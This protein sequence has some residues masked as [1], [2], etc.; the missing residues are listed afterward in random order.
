MWFSRVWLISLVLVTSALVSGALNRSVNQESLEHSAR[1]AELLIERH[2]LQL[3]V[4]SS[5]L[6]AQPEVILALSSQYA[7]ANGQKLRLDH[8]FENWLVDHPIASDAMLLNPGLSKDCPLGGGDCRYQPL[9]AWNQHVTVEDVVSTL[10]LR[11]LKTKETFVPRWG[12]VGEKAHLVV[13]LPVTKQSTLGVL[14]VVGESLEQIVQKVTKEAQRKNHDLKTGFTV[15]LG[16]QRLLGSSTK[17]PNKTVAK[18]EISLLVDHVSPSLADK[19]MNL[20]KEGLSSTTNLLGVIPLSLLFL[21]AFWINRP[22]ALPAQP[23]QFEPRKYEDDELPVE[24]TEELDADRPVTDHSSVNEEADQ[25]SSSIENITDE[26][27]L[28]GLLEPESDQSSSQTIHKVAI[29]EDEWNNPN[30]LLPEPM[31]AESLDHLVDVSENHTENIDEEFSLDEFLELSDQVADDLEQSEE[32]MESLSKDLLT[33]EEDLITPLP[34]QVI[35][36]ADIEDQF[37][38]QESPDSLEPQE[39]SEV[40]L[41]EKEPT[42]SEKE[43]RRPDEFEQFAAELLS[44]SDDSEEGDLVAELGQMF[45]EEL[46]ELFD[47]LESP[48]DAAA[49]EGWE[50]VPENLEPEIDILSEIEIREVEVEAPEEESAEFTESIDPSEPVSTEGFASDYVDFETDLADEL[51]VI[52]DIDL[53]SIVDQHA[54]PE[55]VLDTNMFFSH[56]GLETPTTHPK[57]EEVLHSIAPSPIE[58]QQEDLDLDASLDDLDSEQAEEFNFDALIVPEEFENVEKSSEFEEFTELNEPI[59]TEDINEPDELEQ[60]IF[61]DELVTD[62]QQSEE[63]VSDHHELVEDTTENREELSKVEI[64][65][66]VENSQEFNQDVIAETA[67]NLD[68]SKASESVAEDQIEEVSATPEAVE[69]SEPAVED[70]IE[71]LIEEVLATPEAVEVSEPAAELNNSILSQESDNFDEFIESADSLSSVE[72]LDDFDEDLFGLTDYLD[73]RGIPSLPP[74]SAKATTMVPAISA[75][76][77]EESLEPQ[78]QELDELAP[79]QEEFDALQSFFQAEYGDEWVDLPSTNPNQIEPVQNE[80]TQT[81]AESDSESMLPPVDDLMN[82]FGVD[83]PDDIFQERQATPVPA[84]DELPQDLAE[85]SLLKQQ[86]ELIASEKTELDFPNA[87][88]E[89]VLNTPSDSEDL[90]LTLPPEMEFLPEENQVAPSDS[91]K[92]EEMELDDQ[93]QSQASDVELESNFD[94][95]QEALPAEATELSSPPEP[96]ETFHSH[97]QDEPVQEEAQIQEEKDREL[98]EVIATHAPQPMAEVDWS[99]RAKVRRQARL[100]HYKDVYQEFCTLKKELEAQAKLPNF[101]DFVKQLNTARQQYIDKKNCP[102]VRFKIYRNKKGRAA[103]KAKAYVPEI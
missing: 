4:E 81:K 54:E 66:D 20:F 91:A 14:I 56:L 78:A 80:A 49:Q 44:T 69:V 65:Q 73:E 47:Q 95:A 43:T 36:P 93:V 22:K 16:Q 87:G 71:D 34:N 5:D 41:E 62:H 86:A 83:Q 46:G 77:Y 53:H 100:D 59:E 32:S 1:E 9:R 97:Q 64:A 27:L 15:F 67:V 74:S 92:L 26:D 88:E 12:W 52:E 35:N 70:Q 94:L 29:G 84:S 8:L 37:F 76:V 10:N 102:D 103:I 19:A 96:T 82:I 24:S 57:P 17:S 42:Y 2:T 38:D 28:E 51:S 89:F 50:G 33:D 90:E 25:V 7:E 21:I 79:S 63:V 72:D 48:E 40:V 55:F 75:P 39:I 13:A 58:S 11:S 18:Q 60:L 3:A 61:G 23:Q 101:T 30:S 98:Q 31:G 68:D 99:E 85:P 6:A 45:E